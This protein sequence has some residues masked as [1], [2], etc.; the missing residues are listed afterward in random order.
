M[1][2][3]GHPDL[4]WPMSEQLVQVIARFSLDAISSVL[5]MES[6]VIFLSARDMEMIISNCAVV[7]VIVFDVEIIFGN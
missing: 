3:S 4:V 2:K 6:L 1:T 5:R 7:S